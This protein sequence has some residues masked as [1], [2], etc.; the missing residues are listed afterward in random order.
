M[1][2]LHVKQLAKLSKTGTCQMSDKLQ[3]LCANMQCLHVKQLAKLSKTGTCQMS[4]KL[5]CLCA[6]MQYL[7]VFELD[8]RL[9]KTAPSFCGTKN[10]A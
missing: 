7:Q 6:N 4:D 2:C 10:A 8:A 9:P 1:Q 5:Q 3:C